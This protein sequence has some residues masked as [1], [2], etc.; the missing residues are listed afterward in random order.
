MSKQPTPLSGLRQ[1]EMLADA[2]KA[3]LHP[4]LPPHA[5]V[6]SKYSDKSAN[7]LTRAVVDWFGFQGQFATRLQSTGTYRE[8]LKRYVPSQQRRGLPDVFAVINGRAVH[9]EVKV[10][11]DRL[12][13]DQKEAIKALQAAGAAV[14]VVGT[15]QQFFEWYQTEFRAT[16]F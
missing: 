2:R 15:F 16:P 9:V 5:R 3:E 6:K 10:G 4:T 7:E 14:H 11:N 13:D 1:L 8:D 12:S